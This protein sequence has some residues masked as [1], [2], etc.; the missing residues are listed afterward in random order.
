MIPETRASLLLRVRNSQDQDAW[1]EF[2]EIYSPVV[3]RMATRKGLQPADAD[4]LVQQVLTSVS[5]ALESRPH[6]RE[7]ARFR[8][9]LRRV[10]ENA[11]LN[12]LTRKRPDV[13]S[14][15][16]DFIGLLEQ[17]SAPPEDS[18]L[19]KPELQEEI[20][21]YTADQIRPEFAE[22]TWQAFWLTAVE[23]QECE[24]VAQRLNINIGSVYAARSR[25]M[26][27]LQQKV[28]QYEFGFSVSEFGP[29]CVW[30]NVALLP[31]PFPT[32]PSCLLK[33]HPA[34]SMNWR[35]FSRLI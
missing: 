6:D 21:R 12:A 28:D 8:T 10:A 11:I 29:G 30:N 26:K 18:N 3:F 15:R 27:R 32:W 7:R 23:N 35:I 31:T 16:T 22:S 4:D 2:V 34:H 33:T 24:S 1:R 13:G 5:G 9:W 20:F 25:V 14:G 17:H 19:L